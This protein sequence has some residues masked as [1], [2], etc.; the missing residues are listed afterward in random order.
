MLLIRI[1]VLR[2]WDSSFIFFSQTTMEKK[3]LC[4]ERLAVKE[5]PKRMF[6]KVPIIGLANTINSKDSKKGWGL[7]S[8]VLPVRSAT[9]ELQSALQCAAS[10]KREFMLP[11]AGPG[12]IYLLWHPVLISHSKVSSPRTIGI[13]V[14]GGLNIQA[15]VSLQN[16]S[17]ATWNARNYFLLGLVKS[18]IQGKGTL[19][20]S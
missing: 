10:F 13:F 1:S 19:K 8:F 3:I 12:F 7:H 14:L 16:P 6:I 4:L 17:K 2:A 11:L 5:H 15:L 9:K 20:L 18:H